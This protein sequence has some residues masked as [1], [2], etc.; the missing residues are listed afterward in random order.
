M[1]APKGPCGGM[2]PPACLPLPR[3][4]GRTQSLDYSAAQAASSQAFS[5]PSNFAPTTSSTRAW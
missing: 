4:Q 2:P 5:T 3:K 1:L